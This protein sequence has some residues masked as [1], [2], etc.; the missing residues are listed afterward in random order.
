MRSP[1]PWDW[2]HF[3]CDHLPFEYP[4]FSEAEYAVGRVSGLVNLRIAIGGAEAASGCFNTE[5]V[6]FD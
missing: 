4:F 2:S 6:I 3:P 1:S 5:N